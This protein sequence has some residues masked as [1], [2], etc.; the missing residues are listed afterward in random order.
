MH[1]GAT[2][3]SVD[4][5][6]PTIKV[7]NSKVCTNIGQRIALSVGDVAAAR[8]MYDSITGLSSKILGDT[9][10]N[11]PALAFHDNALFLAWRGS[12]NDNLNVSVSDDRGGSF[13]GKHTS[14]ESSD[15]SP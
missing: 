9:T 4:G 6:K 1:Y 8:V 12:G 5:V 2:S 10:D 14:P 11:G 13:H 7:V 15:D 3:F